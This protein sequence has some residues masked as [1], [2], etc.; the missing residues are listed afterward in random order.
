MIEECLCSSQPIVG[1]Q[2]DDELYV[3]ESSAH[4]LLV[5]DCHKKIILDMQKWSSTPTNQL[6]I[7]LYRLDE[8]IIQSIS[9]GTWRVQIL[10]SRVIIDTPNAFYGVDLDELVFHQSVLET[11]NNDAFSGARIK[12]FILNETGLSNEID[13]NVLRQNQNI[14]DLVEEPEIEQHEAY[15]INNDEEGQRDSG[16]DISCFSN[17]SIF[18]CLRE[19]KCNKLD[20]CK[21][22]TLYNYSISASSKIAELASKC[23]Y[24][25]IL[26]LSTYTLIFEA[27]KLL[28]F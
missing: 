1:D 16:S 23:L 4:I 25:S 26:Y 21:K 28:L 22:D 15:I 6:S 17:S 9:P 12:K 19:L 18:D 3:P 20:R 13:I 11:L 8:L 5:G 7:Y 10:N 2:Q 27:N 24:C 14:A